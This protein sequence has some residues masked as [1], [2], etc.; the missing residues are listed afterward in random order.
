MRKLRNIPGKLAT[1]HSLNTYHMY[2]QAYSAE[3][4]PSTA[5]WLIES[6]PMHSCL[7]QI[8]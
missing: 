4:L 3:I 8:V 2:F 5:N 7:S 6:D 1:V